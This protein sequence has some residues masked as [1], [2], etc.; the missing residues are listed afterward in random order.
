MIFNQFISSFNKDFIR[1]VLVPPFDHSDFE[2][3]FE[4][5]VSL[6][7]TSLSVLF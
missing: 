3:E 6:D 1:E 2:N 5:G 7:F 4:L